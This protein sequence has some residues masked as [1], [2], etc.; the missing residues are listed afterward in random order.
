MKRA[1][2]FVIAA[3][4]SLLAVFCVFGCTPND[5]TPDEPTY[6][7][8]VINGETQKVKAGDKIVKP[9][10]DPTKSTSDADYDADTTYTFSGWYISGTDTAWNFDSD[11]VSKDITLVAKFTEEFNSAVIKPV[12]DKITALP[13]VTAITLDDETAIN[14]AKAAYDALTDSRKG[15][16]SAELVTK[17]EAAVERIDYLKNV[18]PV[19][20]KITALPATDALTLDGETAVNEAKAAYDALTDSRKELVS[21]ELVTKLNAA[22]DKIEQL[23]IAP[24]VDAITA[25]PALA[26]VTLTNRTAIEAAATAYEALSAAR[27]EEVGSELAAKLTGLNEEL[28]RLDEIAETSRTFAGSNET[29]RTPTVNLEATSTATGYTVTYSVKTGEGT[30][31]GDVLTVTGDATVVVTATYKYNTAGNSE[32]QFT[33]VTNIEEA[34]F[35]FE[36]YTVT[37]TVSLDPKFT[38]EHFT[39][40]TTIDLNGNI[41]NVETDGTYTAKMWQSE[42]SVSISALNDDYLEVQSYVEANGD[43]VGIDLQ[44]KYLGYT[45]AGDSLESSE[46]VINYSTGYF[47]DKRIL[48]REHG[49]V[50]NKVIPAGTDFKFSFTVTDN[51]LNKVGAYVGDGVNTFA[52]AYDYDATETKVNF[53]R[54]FGVALNRFNATEGEYTSYTTQTNLKFEAITEDA[55]MDFVLYRVNGEYFLAVTQYEVTRYVALNNA[56]KAAMDEKLTGDIHVGV[57]GFHSDLTFSAGNLDLVL[58]YTDAD[59][60]NHIRLAAYAGLSSENARTIRTEATKFTYKVQI[61]GTYNA[62]GSYPTFTV[63]VTDGDN[64]A[65]AFQIARFN[66]RWALVNN[67]GLTDYVQEKQMMIEGAGGGFGGKGVTGPKSNQT[68]VF[69]PNFVNSH[70]H[71]VPLNGYTEGTVTKPARM[72]EEI[73][74]I[75]DGAYLGVYE[76][77]D[78]YGGRYINVGYVYLEG[79]ET[80][81]LEISGAVCTKSNGFAAN[82]VG[83]SF[84]ESIDTQKLIE[85]TTTAGRASMITYDN[86]FEVEFL[87]TEAITSQQYMRINVMLPTGSLGV[88]SPNGNNMYIQFTRY[89]ARWVALNETGNGSSYTQENNLFTDTNSGFVGMTDLAK[90]LKTVDASTGDGKYNLAGNDNNWFTPTGSTA[91]SVKIVRHGNEFRCYEKNSNKTEYFCFAIMTLDGYENLPVGVGIK[92]ATSGSGNILPVPNSITYTKLEPVTT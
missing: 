34:T 61:G 75:R 57:I 79:M 44:F 6:Y 28:D 2:S 9:A 58:N 82:A 27:K 60:D 11:T 42:G 30:I 50:V 87:V 67:T 41:A 59:F 77:N 46:A 17:L 35:T 91:Y 40:N 72:P 49:V 24:V 16:V 62:A 86:D 85:A 4:L 10:T 23:Y 25:L 45:F 29:L 70:D 43:R 15:H 18:A 7:N 21:A 48:N 54:I 47:T 84:T 33:N 8:V 65:S 63:K 3:I 64:N 90:A 78:L 13:E 20:A 55:P 69:E 74:L 52:I 73:M 80:G 71:L 37:G 51:E 76:L 1:K 88:N 32:V 83:A 53:I 66:T 26:D 22:L 12:V 38:D 81:A 92:K 39:E 14:D 31:D 19:E 89:N 36:Q 56:M 5:E 68:P